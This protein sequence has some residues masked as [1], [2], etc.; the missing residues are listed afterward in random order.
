MLFKYRH[1]S[2][3]HPEYQQE[4]RF[5]S[6]FLH[7]LRNSMETL[8]F[9]EVETPLLTRSSPEVRPRPLF[10]PRARMSCSCR[11]FS[12]PAAATR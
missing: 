1:L 12:C 7:S 9:T 2:L 6:S 11:R 5:R 8:G 10:N 3:R 4:I